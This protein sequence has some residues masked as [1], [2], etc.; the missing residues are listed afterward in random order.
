MEDESRLDGAEEVAAEQSGGGAG[1]RPL[2]DEERAALLREELKA[3][4]VADMALDMMLSLVTVGYQ[5][6][7]LT[8]ETRELRDLDGA[9]LAIELLRGMIEALGSA[10]GESAVAPYR[11]TLATMQMNYARVVS[12]PVGPDKREPGGSGEPGER[13]RSDETP[14]EPERAETPSD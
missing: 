3:L 8:D 12:E 1:E 11:S 5:K 10:Q 6:L 14:V 7:G 4:R 2:T 9:R 13:K